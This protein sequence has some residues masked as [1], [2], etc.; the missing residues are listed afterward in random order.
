MK[1]R[2]PIIATILCIAC[3]SFFMWYASQDPVQPA[4]KPRPAAPEPKPISPPIKEEPPAPA[5]VPPPPP[6]AP[7]ETA[8]ADGARVTGIVLSADDGKPI[9]DTEVSVGDT[10]KIK[11]GPDGR[12][13]FDNV[14]INATALK[15]VHAWYLD[16]SATFQLQTGASV[17]VR[18]E[19]KGCGGVE[20][21]VFRNGR[22]S[23]GEQ[24]LIGHKEQTV[25]TDERGHYQSLDESPGEVTVTVVTDSVAPHRL[26]PKWAFAK[27]TVE[28]GRT[29]VVD[30]DMPIMQS[31]VEGAILIEG[32]PPDKASMHARISCDY[33][34][35]ATT[36]EVTPDGRY[37]IANLPAGTLFLNANATGPTGVPRR[38]TVNV[39][40]PEA[41]AVQY[42]FIF[43]AGGSVSGTVTG[44][45]QDE[46]VSILLMKGSA[47]AGREFSFQEMM[48]LGQGIVGNANPEADG[49]FRIEGI[50]PGAHT[51]IALAVG[52][53]TPGR[54]QDASNIRST[55]KPVTLVEGKDVSVS[56][57]FR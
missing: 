51:V 27:A 53:R 57:S 34:D 47:P 25:A 56:L 21:V 9:P 44:A 52:A 2:L 30:F 14:P 39:D 19:L 12:F 49:T 28:Q 23:S 8:A 36:A 31:Q 10:M 45:A 4:P 29:T 13:T 43:T 54:D 11:T 15:A 7:V 6:P 37:H 16:G 38:R 33:G 42:D 50:D 3:A 32:Q 5:P 41:R 40:V 26:P 24:L 17:E 48:T 18:V 55:S 46:R 35:Y 22:P 1:T 20:G